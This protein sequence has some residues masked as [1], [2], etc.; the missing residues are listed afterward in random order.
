MSYEQTVDKFRFFMKSN[1]FDTFLEDRY[2]FGGI[3]NQE[4]FAVCLELPLFNYDEIDETD[5]FND[6]K[7]YDLSICKTSNSKNKPCVQ[8]SVLL[9][10]LYSNKLC[11]ETEFYAI[12]KKIK[13]LKLRFVLN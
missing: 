3:N 9:K 8:V 5:F 4:F 11:Q 10:D 13:D 12:L 2:V 6:Q 1:H 7:N